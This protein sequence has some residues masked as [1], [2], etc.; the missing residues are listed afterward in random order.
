MINL[1]LSHLTFLEPMMHPPTIVH[2]RYEAEGRL[3]PYHHFIEVLI[4]SSA[5]YAIPVKR[6]CAR[7][8]EMQQRRQH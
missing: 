5:I 7:N 4:K 3:G 8:L 2:V 1:M 6:L